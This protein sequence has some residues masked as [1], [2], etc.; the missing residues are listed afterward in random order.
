MTTSVF[1]LRRVILRRAVF[2]QVRLS[3]RSYHQIMPIY[4]QYPVLPMDLGEEWH[5]WVAQVR[6]VFAMSVSS[7]IMELLQPPATPRPSAPPASCGGRQRSNAKQLLPSDLKRMLANNSQYVCHRTEDSGAG[8]CE[9]P[10]RAETDQ[11]KKK[12]PTAP[13]GIYAVVGVGG[14]ADYGRYGIVYNRY[15]RVWTRMGGDVLCSVAELS[16]D[17]AVGW[18]LQE[19]LEE[20]RRL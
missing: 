15:D 16:T 20:A 9:E 1:L 19:D 14:V 18:F 3:L 5:G 2:N 8:T 7:W 11:A 4:Q 17:E 12:N 13:F 6:P 10:L